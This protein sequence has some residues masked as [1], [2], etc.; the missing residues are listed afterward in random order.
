MTWLRWLARAL[1]RDRLTQIALAILF[2]LLFVSLLAPLLPVGRPDQVGFGPRLG[3][4]TWL[5]PLGTDQLGRPVLARVLQGVH[6]SIF[7]ST[8][9][10][11]VSGTLGAIAAMA[12]TYLHPVAAEAIN[13]I[14]DVMFSFPPI[15][16]GILVVTVL[17]PGI[18]SAMVVVALITFP[19]MLRVVGAATLSVM[20]RDFVVISEIA[21]ASFLQRLT[22][23][24]LP[25]VAETIVVQMVYSISIGMLVESSLSFLGIG[26]QPP[27]A[28][29]GSLLKD[30]V[31]YIE[32]A[33]WL[34]F[35]AGITLAAAILAT[36][37][38]GDGLR[39]LVDP[40]EQA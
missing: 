11:L 38:I 6:T 19:T 31:S 3:G 20:R 12:M 23:H 16:L 40:V 33:P 2:L 22:V 4:P 10:V 35:G 18:I 5:V 39:R 34:T 37:L 27:I 7:L 9:A 30:G 25:N 32:I 1:K 17:W 14:A 13:R 36:N 26:V 24:L 8:F 15:L 28:S 29:L 21:G